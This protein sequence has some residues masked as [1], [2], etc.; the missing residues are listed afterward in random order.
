MVLNGAINLNQLEATIASAVEQDGRYSRENDAKFRAV[1]QKVQSFE[2]FEGIVKASHIKPMTEDVTNLSLGR[3]S[4][5]PNGR[6]FHLLTLTYREDR[7][8]VSRKKPR[9]RFRLQRC[10]LHAAQ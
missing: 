3:S 1:A 7:K 6:Y 8:L 10:Q 5:N 4:W 9:L 2:E